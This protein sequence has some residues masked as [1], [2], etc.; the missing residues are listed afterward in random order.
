MDYEQLLAFFKTFSK[1]LVFQYPKEGKLCFTPDSLLGFVVSV[2]EGSKD[3]DASELL[4][5]LRTTFGDD[6]AVVT[7]GS[8]GTNY[9]TFDSSSVSKQGLPYESF[10]YVYHVSTLDQNLELALGFSQNSYV[11]IPRGKYYVWRFEVEK[12]NPKSFK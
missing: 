7:F 8:R 10:G 12:S 2:L 3:P 9:T 5:L 1:F 6:V 4:G 11:D